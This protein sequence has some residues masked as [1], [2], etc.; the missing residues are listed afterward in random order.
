MS[1]RMRTAFL[2]A[3]M[4][5]LLLFLLGVW[6]LADSYLRIVRMNELQQATAG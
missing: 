3:S 4:V 6:A 5:G 2:L 1:M